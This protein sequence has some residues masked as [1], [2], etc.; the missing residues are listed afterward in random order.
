VSN[1]RVE[2]PQ[3]V[4]SA[5]FEDSVV[6]INL[7]SKRYYMLN[8]TAGFIWRGIKG[9]R[10]ESD[11]IEKMCL[12]YDATTER[13]TASVNRLFDAFKRADLIV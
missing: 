3:F 11:I 10:S 9:G 4:I 5:E 8:D 7:N 6:V 13:I 2:I 1:R 12:E